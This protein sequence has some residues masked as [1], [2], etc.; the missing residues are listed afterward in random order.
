MTEL[1]TKLAQALGSSKYM[2]ELF[3]KNNQRWK[4]KDGS[5]QDPAGAHALLEEIPKLLKAAFD[6]AQSTPAQVTEAAKIAIDARNAHLDLHAGDALGGMQAALAAAFPAMTQ[7]VEAMK[8]SVHHWRRQYNIEC[9]NLSKVE[10]E[11]DN[12]AAEVARLSAKLDSATRVV[13]GK[14]FF[15]KQR[16]GV[17]NATTVALS[18]LLDEL[19]K[20]DAAIQSN[21]EGRDA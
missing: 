17:G 8:E 9:E 13:G 10:A 7:Q 5:M 3:A 18:Q 11:R 4:R 20:S 21:K 2:V 12:L 1:E 16:H 15:F 19:A 6:A 14:Y